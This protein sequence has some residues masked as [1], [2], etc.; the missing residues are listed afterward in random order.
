MI[1]LISLGEPL[2]GLIGKFILAGTVLVGAIGGL[3]LFAS[4]LSP[5]TS[6][7]K[8]LGGGAADLI[9]GVKS[10]GKS[11]RVPFFAT[12]PGQF[13]K[14]LSGIPALTGTGGGT[15][16]GM[17]GATAAGTVTFGAYSGRIVWSFNEHG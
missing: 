7:L 3:K 6:I 1:G 4:A 15:W 5:V 14:G 2:Q 12:A 11:G 10:G 17:T 9:P 8:G 16:A 13:L